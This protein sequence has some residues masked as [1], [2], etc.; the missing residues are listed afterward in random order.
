[1]FCARTPST[2]FQSS[3]GGSRGW[4]HGWIDGILCGACDGKKAILSLYRRKYLSLPCTYIRGGKGPLAVFNLSLYIYLPTF[5]I[6][7]GPTLLIKSC[8]FPSLSLFFFR[9]VC[10]FEKSVEIDGIFT[11]FN[12]LHEQESFISCF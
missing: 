4:Y 12:D 1:M 2:F 3:Y 7:H 11:S 10:T 6:R 5:S 8:L 9:N